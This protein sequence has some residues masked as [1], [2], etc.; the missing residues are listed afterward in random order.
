MADALTSRDNQLTALIIARNEEEMI[1]NCVETLR[2]AKEIVVL[3]TGSTDHT[4]EIAERLGCTVLHAKGSNFADW[5]NEVAQA[6]HTEWSFYV[7]ADERVTPA[8]AKAIQSRILR[9]DYDAYRIF[10]NNIHYGKWLQH[11][12]W[13]NDSLLRVFRTAKLKGWVGQVHEHAEIVGRVGEIEEPL[14]HLTHRS[15]FDGLRKSIDWTDI[16]ARLFLQ[17]GHPKVGPLRLMK[18]VVFDFVKRLLFKR[19]WKD[20]SEGIIEAMIQSMNRFLVYVRLWELQQKPSVP[21][22]YER[23]EK[24]IEKQWKNA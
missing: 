3:D 20:G 13:G 18:V 24:E 7:D 1:A 15:L 12:G 23:I 22:R 16:E 11:G 17:S 10:R 5:R 14:V 9:P 2:W 6:V 21:H 8:L 19:A 4:A